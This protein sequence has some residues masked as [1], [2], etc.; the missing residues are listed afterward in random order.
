MALQLS[1]SA[2]HVGEACLSHMSQDSE[3]TAVWAVTFRAPPK[4]GEDRK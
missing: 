1:W 2:D 3:I 4:E